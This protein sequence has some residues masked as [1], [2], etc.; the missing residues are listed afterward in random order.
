MTYSDRTG[1]SK[2]E[3]PEELLV[4]DSRKIRLSGND[5]WYGFTIGILGL[6]LGSYAIGRYC[7][8]LSIQ[9]PERE[10]LR[11]EGRTITGTVNRILSTRRTGEYVEYSFL[12]FGKTYIG[13]AHLADGK[14]DIEGNGTILIKYLPYD[15]NVNH[16]AAWE[17]S[18]LTGLNVVVFAVIFAS[19]GSFALI[20]LYREKEILKK[21]NLVRGEVIGCE[22]RKSIFRVSYLFTTDV[23]IQIEGSSENNEQYGRGDN[24]WVLYLPKDPRRNRSY[25]MLYFTVCE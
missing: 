10:A 15:P 14:G 16:P 6:L 22:P 7:Y 8:D 2:M 19:I 18:A 12:I 9:M 13:K 11:K 5:A 20:Y 17:W 24:I 4:R 25:P 21:G 1:E 3:I 23:G